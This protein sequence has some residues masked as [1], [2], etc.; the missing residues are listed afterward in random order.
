MDF[1][2]E[3]SSEFREASVSSPKSTWKPSMGHPNVQVFLKQ[4]KHLIIKEFQSPLGYSN[5]SKKE[6]KSVRFLANDCNV[7][8]KKADKGSCVVI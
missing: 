3:P 4:I 8:I 1:R 2:N 6:W 7:V 5:L